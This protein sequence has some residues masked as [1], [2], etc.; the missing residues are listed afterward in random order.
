[1]SGSTAGG[2]ELRDQGTYGYLTQAA[3]GAKA[4]RE[5]FAGS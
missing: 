2:D 4:A 1:M 3:A 5:A